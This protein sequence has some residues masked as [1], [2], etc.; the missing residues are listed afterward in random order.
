MQKSRSEE[1]SA[2]YKP[3]DPKVNFPEQERKMLKKWGEEKTFARSVEQRAGKT[4]YVFYDGPPFATGLPHYGH[5]LVGAIKD[6]FLRYQTMKGRYV[7]RRFGWDCH[8]LPVEYEAEKELGI[9]G[10]SEIEEYGATRFNEYCRSIVQRYTGEWRDVVAR[11]G[12]WVD[13]DNEYL[14]MD[15]DYMESIWWVVKRLW[16]KKLIFKGHYI[17]PYCP[18]CSTVLSNHEL[19]LGGYKD[20]HDPAITVRFRLR[21]N[22]KRF[23]LAWTT[24]PWTLISNQML[25]L[26]GDIDYV[27]VKVAEGEEELIVARER[28]AALFKSPEEYEIIEEMKGSKLAGISYEPVFSLFMEQEK[29]GAFKTILADFVSTEDGTGIVHA[30]SGFGE[31]DYNAVNPLDIPPLTPIDDECR[32]TAEVDEYSGLFVKDADKKIIR[33]LKERGLL[34][35]QDQYLH[36]YPHCWRCESPLIY[37]AVASWFVDIPAIK[38]TMIRANEEIY[39]MPGHLKKGRFG[40][41][42]ENARNWAISRNRYWGNPI[43][44][45]ECGECD[46]SVCI[47]G[48][49]ELTQLSGQKIDDI[50]KHFVDEITIRCEK[51]G[52][53]M[54][55]TPEVLDCWFES[56]A[57]PYAQLHYPFENKELFEEIFPADYINE[58]IDQTRG[59]FYTLVILGAALFEKPPFK[60]CVVS[61]MILAADGKKMSKSA[62]NYTDP[63]T[64]MDE[65]GADAMRLYMLSSSVVKGEPIRFS[66]EGVKEVLRSIILPLWNAYSFFVTYANIDGVTVSSPP[67]SPE[68]PLDQWILSEAERLVEEYGDA[69]EAYDLPASVTPILNF[70]DLLNN[71]YI[72]RSRRR[73]WKSENDSDKKEGYQTLW[74]ALI[75]LLH[76]AAP[77]IPFI[78]DAIYANLKEEGM[79]D[80]V[81]LADFPSVDSKRRN[82]AM[83]KKMDVAR[84]AVSM[85]RALR[86]TYNL[87]TRQPLKSIHLVTRDPEE[88]AILYE[89]E[90]LI[91]EE[92][93]VKEVIHREDEEDVVSYE[94]KANY[95]ILGK[96]LGKDMKAAAAAIA[97]IDSEGAR[98]LL[99]GATLSIDFDGVSIKNIDIT[100]DNVE[101]VRN[102]KAGLRVNTDGSL[103]V[104]LD[105][106]ITEELRIEG[107]ARDLVR[108]IQN[109]RKEM[110]LEVSD[111]IVLTLFGDDAAK[112]VTETFRETISSETLAATLEW[113]DSAA[114]EEFRIGEGAVV[115]AEIVKV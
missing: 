4:P 71:W 39:W 20:V 44:V 45:W 59:W 70:I 17:L 67:E 89:L 77:V 75:K 114:M 102:E 19:N 49:D 62:R 115:K 1:N 106:E 54:R 81:H 108:K 16:E 10:K 87:K 7:P 90:E 13:F 41:W 14:T 31:D 42:L 82:V 53:E 12:R 50:H 80:S 74:G 32:F 73:F 3:V 5:I 103:T 8:G 11:S 55:R 107:M 92:L 15:T 61:G 51:C 99:D 101:I 29:L 105:P 24:T 111:R 46:H 34:F 25:I 96:I 23:F 6:T 95:R 64:L 97:N 98:S 110:N 63:T 27:C 94:V 18:R 113:K 38:E 30:A 112:V 84:R 91:E 76:V 36:S 26:G 40:K 28:L 58:S 60:N 56:G 93:N 2:M 52:S 21:E 78:T 47:G 68:N 48:K 35:A 9:S 33:N 43:P 57:M 83:E 100:V 104:A 109:K 79:A 22:P 72:R 69:M 37:R 86:S 85:G 66:D 65:F 88:K